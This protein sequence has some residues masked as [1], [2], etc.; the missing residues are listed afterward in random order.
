MIR[1][2]VLQNF[3]R[4]RSSVI[5]FTPGLN[6][7]VGDNEAG[8]STL[9]E[10]INLGLTKRWNGRFFDVEFSHHFITLSAVAEYLA[11]VAAGNNPQPPE[12]LVEVYLKDDPAVAKLK[13]ENNSLRED[14]PGYRLR[15]ALDP[16]FA[17]EYKAFL[18]NP[19]EVKTVPTEFY[20]VEWT[21]FASQAVNV[22]AVRVKASLIDA[23]RI[24]LQSGTD[25]HLQKIIGET[26]DGKQRAQLARSY[27]LHQELFGADPAIKAINAS[28][29]G[30]SGDV[31]SK[32]FTMEIDTS[33]ANGWESALA[34]HLDRLPFHFSGSGEQNRV[35]ILL[36]LTRKFQDSH[37]ILIEEPENHLS[38]SNLNDLVDRIAGQS[39][40]RQLIIA[41]HSSYV[42]NKL[43][44]DQLMLLGGGDSATRLTALSPDTQSYF[45]K[46]AGYDTLRLVLAKKVVLV[47]GP[48]DELVFQRAYL[49]RHSRR[50]IENGVDVISVRGLSAKR[51]L[52]LAIPLQRTA[53]L[54]CDNDGD[55]AKKVDERFADYG[56]HQFI[57]I[58]RSDEDDKPTLE[59][60]LLAV[61]GLARVNAILNRSFT[62]DEKFLDYAKAHKT[63]VA[64][65]FHDTTEPVTWPKYVEDAIDALG[66]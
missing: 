25:Y 24:R 49:D 16:D 19:T 46:L 11:E 31:T 15:A 34:P 20:R 33:G 26:L 45:K 62:T 40:G 4:F 61:N 5:E 44:L 27:R 53:V 57:A 37:V 50:P 6:I 60:Q 18:E 47:E 2:I 66:E 9:L 32:S 51:F 30:S 14:A 10:A 56:T 28:L 21:D 41:T 39:A 17:D 55:H 22:R 38:F 54:L 8:K 35:K 42:V 64:L 23:S 65:R 59:P 58:A 3:K 63:E 13:G 1:K 48:S 36:A 43:G 7:L 52:D 12:L 29:T